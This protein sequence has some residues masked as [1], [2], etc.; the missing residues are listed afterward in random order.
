MQ[1]DFDLDEIY[2]LY[3]QDLLKEEAIDFRR[4]T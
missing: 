3:A 1:N 4:V 2:N